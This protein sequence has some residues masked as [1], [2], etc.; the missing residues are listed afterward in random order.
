MIRL[1][2][3]KGP[4]RSFQRRN[5]RLLWASDISQRCAEQMEF[6]VLAWY[7]LA[8]TNSPFLVGLFGA[9]RFFGTLLA[10]PYG[11]LA[12]RY[13]RRRLLVGIRLTFAVAAATVLV[14]FFTG[15]LKVWQ[16]FVLMGVFGAYRAF[17]SVTRQAVLADVMEGEG[18]TNALALTRTGQDAAQMVGPLIGGALLSRFGLGWA[19]LPI[20]I[21]YLMGAFFAYLIHPPGILRAVLASSMWRNLAAVGRY[22]RKHDVVLALL[23]MAFLI[24]LAA[25]PLTHGLVAVFARDVLGTGPMGLAAL[26]WANSAGAFLGSLGLASRRRLSRPGRFLVVSV[27]SWLLAMLV[28]SQSPMI[29]VSLVVLVIAGAA[30]SFSIVTL[31][32]LL[33]HVIPFEL[34]GR[35]M[36]VRSM[37][38]YGLP[39][40]L[41]ASGA[42]ADTL[43]APIALAIISIAGA[44]LAVLVANRLSRLWAYLE[45]EKGQHAVETVAQDP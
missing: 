14:L 5:Y 10:A 39:V 34:R 13:D 23:I 35:V 2:V 42:L 40:G 6:L 9:L 18:V 25:F 27:L 41:L 24:N 16:V 45:E 31:D 21:T 1:L 28:F 32:T 37:A 11:V 30:Q 36:G 44:A 38:V 15:H 7:V 12:D 22:V 17:D 19:Y 26:L 43:G 33:L 29:E 3:T 8:E 4:L 20:V